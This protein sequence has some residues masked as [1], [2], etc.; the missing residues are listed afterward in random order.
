MP[1]YSGLSSLAEGA[2]STPSI[3]KNGP[4]ANAWCDLRTWFACQCYVATTKV[5][6]RARRNVV[7]RL[8]I[9]YQIDLAPHNHPRIGKHCTP[10]GLS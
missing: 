4:Q 8:Q 9:R 1:A 6:E 10:A 2:A 5:G 3:S 7:Y